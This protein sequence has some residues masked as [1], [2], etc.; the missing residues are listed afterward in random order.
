MSEDIDL[1]MAETLAEIRSR[2][3]AEEPAEEVVDEVAEEVVE[4]VTAEVTEEV[5]AEEEGVEEPEE[6][7]EPEKPVVAKSNAPAS[8]RPAAKSKWESLDPEVQ[9]EILKREEDTARGVTPLKEK[10]TFGDRLSQA[11][12]P[13]MPM[14]QA[15]G[16]TLEQFITGQG[17][18]MYG[19]QY[20]TQ[21][22]KVSIL[23]GMAQMAGIDLARI[24]PP[25]EIERQ[26][27]P[28][29]Q[30]ITTLEQQIAAQ[31]NEVA[32]AEEAKI[33]QALT[34]FE[35]ELDA[36]GN[37]KHPYFH[38]VETEMIAIIPIIRQN[39]PSF[40]YAE[41]LQQAYDNSIWTNPDTR[42][43]IQVQQDKAAE[44]ERKRKAKEIADKAK[45][46]N[47]VNLPKKGQQNST[48]AEDLGSI[49]ET[50]AATLKE[51]KSR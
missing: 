22:Q 46:A 23:R 9:A 15:K 29:M 38:N 19:L 13:Y 33:N 35:N 8:W 51:I 50:I 12:A 45:K 34:S 3:E 18:T 40:S 39:N 41:V 1:D 17:N 25:S 28:Y 6:P 14:I 44:A 37:I 20:G 36:S 30:K 32:S 2:E 7:K 26:L 24:P 21:E 48:Q 31:R 43:L 47:K 42:K 16:A 10:A 5:V 27:S 11:A 49:D 4:E